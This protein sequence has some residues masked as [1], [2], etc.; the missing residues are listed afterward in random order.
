MAHGGGFGWATGQPPNT[1][2]FEAMALPLWREALVGMDWLTLRASPVYRGMGV[3]PGG[4]GVVVLTPGFLGP[5]QALGDLFPWL[6]RIGYQPYMS[7][8]GRNAECPDMLTGRLLAS[9]N[10]A[11]L[12]GGREVHL[13]GH[14]LG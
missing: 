1:E 14:N 4:G 7:G 2:E 12:E 9:V 13:V 5:D 6:R 3:A 8:M 11:C 10:S